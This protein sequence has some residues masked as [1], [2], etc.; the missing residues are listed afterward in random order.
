M[1]PIFSKRIYTEI[2]CGVYR[3][4]N[5]RTGE[6]YVGSG[7]NVY[8]RWRVHTYLLIRGVHR[9]GHLQNSWNLDSKCWIF[10]ILEL[11]SESGLLSREDYW[12]Q[13]YDAVNSGYNIASSAASPMRG[14]KHTAIGI[15]H[16]KEGH[17]D[18]VP[19]ANQ[20]AALLGPKSE[21]H[22]QRISKALVKR[23]FPG[24]HKSKPWTQERRAAFSKLKQGCAGWKPTE[25]QKQ[26][27]SK[28]AIERGIKPSRA[29]I[30]K[31]ALARRKLN[32]V[33][34]P[35]GK[36]LS[37]SIQQPLKGAV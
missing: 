28:L 21:R 13:S 27:K 1:R 33:S 29:A 26:A 10:G 9:N 24:M 16:L 17:R 35:L 14:R 15:Q 34:P 25:Q 7:K 23:V 31:S 22:K 32:C 3:I 36:E 30:E 6:S 37:S 4:L 11:V 19:N 20:R 8:E 18:Y 2:L 5:L 12:I